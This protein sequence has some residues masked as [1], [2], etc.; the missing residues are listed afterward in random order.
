MIHHDDPTPGTRRAHP[1]RN[2]VSARRRGASRGRHHRTGAAGLGH[3]NRPGQWRGGGGTVFAGPLRRLHR[4]YRS[5]RGR[6]PAGRAVERLR[7]AGRRPVGRRR[8]GL[9]VLPG[10]AFADARPNRHRS[11][12][13]AVTAAGRPR[14]PVAANRAGQIDG[15]APEIH[16][17]LPG[18]A[19][20]QCPGPPPSRR[21]G[22]RNLFPPP[23]HSFRRRNELRPDRGVRR[24]GA[25][26][27]PGRQPAV[28]RVAGGREQRDFLGQ[29]HLF[30]PQGTRKRRRRF[31]ARTPGHRARLRLAYRIGPIGRND[32]RR[33]PRFPDRV[34][35]SSRS[36]PALR[37][38][39]HRGVD[40][41]PFPVDRG[42]PPLARRVR[43]LSPEFRGVE[44]RWRPGHRHSY[45]RSRR[46]EGVPCSKP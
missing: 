22:Y 19:G 9:R 36:R 41:H 20:L 35:R 34:R 25:S 18:L 32:C 45:R 13:L 40:H 38:R 42:Q 16:R 30:D 26:P 6:P 4:L 43:P 37:D 28:P 1:P 23:P 39:V 29:R 27:G 33:D 5:A 8:R 46:D 3:R 7:L 44:G 15:M 17:A 12:R 31:P 2:L 10:T 21:R 24:P 14:R 11:G